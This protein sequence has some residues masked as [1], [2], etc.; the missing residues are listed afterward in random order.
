MYLELVSWF[1]QSHYSILLDNSS[2]VSLCT[3][4]SNSFLAFL[5]TLGDSFDVNSMLKLPE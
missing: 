3:E 5:Y 2:R 4:R 1:V